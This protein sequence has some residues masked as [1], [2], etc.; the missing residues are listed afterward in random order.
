MSPVDVQCLA[1]HLGSDR[2]AIAH[3]NRRRRPVSIGEWSR[4]I[5]CKHGVRKLS[6]ADA[7]ETS[8]CVKTASETRIKYHPS[9][10]PEP[11]TLKLIDAR[12]RQWL[13]ATSPAGREVGGWR[14]WR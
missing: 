3:D 9:A 7:P 13:S 4:D 11:K 1:G 12:K 5:Y 14:G 2:A 8:E 6:I 10:A